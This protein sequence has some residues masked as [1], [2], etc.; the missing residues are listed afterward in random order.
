MG[1]HVKSNQKNILTLLTTLIIDLHYD[2]QD[3]CTH[4]QGTEC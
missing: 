3:F 4:R 2:G 1:T